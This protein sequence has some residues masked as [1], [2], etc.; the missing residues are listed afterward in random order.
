MILKQVTSLRWILITHQS[1]HNDY[2]LAPESTNFEPSPFMNALMKQCKSKPSDVDKLIPNLH[3]KRKYVVHYRNLKQYI[4]QGMKLTHIHRVIAF[5]QSAWLKQYIDFNTDMRKQAKNNFE[6]DFWK[7]MNNSVFDKFMEN[8]RHR[9]DVKLE[10]TAQKAEKHINKPTLKRWKEFNNDLIG[11]ELRKKQTVLNKPIAIG[12]CILDLSKTLMYYFHYNYMKKEYGDNVQLL[13][14]DTDSLVYQV[15]T[16]DLYKDF[17]KHKD[18]YDFSEY[19]SSPT[20][21]Q[22]M[23]LA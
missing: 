14:T 4:D 11:I 1:L 21:R 6:K 22:N 2:P 16:K 10:T 7:L 12:F 20:L 13:Y 5:D 23:H 17:Q 8:V 19:P 15:F 18:K 3:N 9:V